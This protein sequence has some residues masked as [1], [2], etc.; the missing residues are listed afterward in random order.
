MHATIFDDIIKIKYNFLKSIKYGEKSFQPGSLS[1]RIKYRINE[2]E[3]VEASANICTSL[4][5]TAVSLNIWNKSFD[6]IRLKIKLP[7]MDPKYTYGIFRCRILNI[8]DEKD[9]K[10]CSFREP[11]DLIAYATGALQGSK[12]LIGVAGFLDQLK[13]EARPKANY[14]TLDRREVSI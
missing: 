7:E 12:I 5:Y 9:G 14:C 3:Y 11:F 4:F 10:E 1:C 8:P 2:K 6:K 13:L